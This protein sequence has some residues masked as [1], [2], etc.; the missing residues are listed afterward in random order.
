MYVTNFMRYYWGSYDPIDE[1]E[2]YYQLVFDATMRTRRRWD[3]KIDAHR[4][5]DEV[6]RSESVDYALLYDLIMSD[7]LISEG[8]H[9]WAE[10]IQLVWTKI[11]AFIDAFD[12]GR[13]ILIIRDPRS[14]LASFKKFTYEPE[15]AYLGAIFNM[16]DVLQCAKT[17]S[18]QFSS[19]RFHTIR[20]EDIVYE[21]EETLKAAFDFLDLSADHD[22]LSEAGWT[23]ASGGPWRTNSAYDNDKFDK[24]AAVHRWK[25]NLEP[26]ELSLCELIVGDEMAEFG[27]EPQEPDPP[28]KDTLDVLRTDPELS[29][30]YTRWKETGEGVESY[31]SDPTDPDN[32]TEN[33]PDA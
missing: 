30:Y 11:P 23:G 20:Y 16:L 19:D 6:D 2:N 31:P 21:P 3:R 7:L 13:A 29:Q 17:Y 25:G 8:V 4:I 26:W 18:Q 9:H 15:P 5:L 32:W 33:V 28:D 12:N 22:L 1:V 24:D 27:Y 14:V 10:K